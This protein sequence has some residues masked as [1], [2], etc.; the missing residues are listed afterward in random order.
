MADQEQPVLE[1][2][3]P[4]V[5]SRAASKK[6]VALLGSDGAWLLQ[7]TIYYGWR[8]YFDVAI[9]TVTGSSPQRASL[10]SDPWPLEKEFQ[11]TVDLQ[12]QG[13]LYAVAE[14]L[15][16]LLRSCRCHAGSGE[17]F[18][19]AYV[20][21]PNVRALVDHA[22]TTTRDELGELLL[23]PR[24]VD[25]VKAAVRDALPDDR[26]PRG[27]HQDLQER[28]LQDTTDIG[29]LLIPKSAIE[30]GALEGSLRSTREM[31]DLLHAN[32][33]QLK[34]LTEQPGNVDPSAELK[35]QPLREVDNSFRHGLRV[36]YPAALPERRQFASLTGA[37]FNALS[38]YTVDL[39]L[40]RGD[41]TV[42]YGTVDG[43]PERTREH[44]EAI[45]QLSTRTGQLARAFFGA[46]IIGTPALT[47][48]ASGLELP[49]LPRL[50]G[51]A[52]DESSPAEGGQ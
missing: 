33:I 45:R 17:S 20:T 21:A 44:L 46:Q 14:Q 23:E 36:L 34:G 4:G 41:D 47:I 7:S 49:E 13:L 32:V 16:T 27:N 38:E 24:S 43:R 42:R 5:F 30:R 26:R 6:A 29:E 2:T 8:A 11:A 52:E 19:D 39:Y 48:S 40:P 9:A 18:L 37:R 31:I 50:L 12:V 1:S 28:M 22:Q 10:D 15:L 25:D 3:G 35:P 51:E